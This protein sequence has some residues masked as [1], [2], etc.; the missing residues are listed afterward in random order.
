MA[1]IKKSKV[2][3]VSFFNGDSE[4]TEQEGKEKL[5]QE[6]SLEEK[7]EIKTTNKKDN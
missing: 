7:K 4:P 2:E 3:I 6:A 5:S 1:F